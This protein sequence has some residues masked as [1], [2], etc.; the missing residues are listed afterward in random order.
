MHFNTINTDILDLSEAAIKAYKDLSGW[1]DLRRRMVW[2]KEQNRPELVF[3]VLSECHE[4]HL[5][6]SLI[7]KFQFH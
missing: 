4:T 6:V 2:I 5:S 3:V 1:A 7:E